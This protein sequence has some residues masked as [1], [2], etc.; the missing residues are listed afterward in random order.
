MDVWQR[1]LSVGLG[2]VLVCGALVLLS[3]PLRTAK[4][5]ENY[6]FRRS[7]QEVARGWLGKTIFLPGRRTTLIMAL[8]IAVAMFTAAGFSFLAAYS[9]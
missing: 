7:E 5:I 4:L 1:A 6:Y 9:G 3:S 8:L 2:L